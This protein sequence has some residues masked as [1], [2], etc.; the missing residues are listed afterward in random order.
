MLLL[1]D[2]L[3]RLYCCVYPSQ[4]TSKG[5]KD[6]SHTG[7]GREVDEDESVGSGVG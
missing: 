7:I 5:Q 4:K 1:A 2:E 3:E 6:H